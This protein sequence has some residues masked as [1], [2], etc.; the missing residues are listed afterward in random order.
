MG[1][2]YSQLVRGHGNPR[3]LSHDLIAP[4]SSY[5]RMRSDQ[6]DRRMMVECRVMTECRVM[7]DCRVMTEFRV[8]TGCRVMT[9]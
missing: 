3:A 7:I 8:M 6:I 1:L 2:T 9:Q 4:L 5:N